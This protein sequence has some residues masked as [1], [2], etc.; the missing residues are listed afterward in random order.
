[1]A[2]RDALLQLAETEDKD[3]FVHPERLLVTMTRKE[4]ESWKHRLKSINW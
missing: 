4:V 3:G 1:V 2:I